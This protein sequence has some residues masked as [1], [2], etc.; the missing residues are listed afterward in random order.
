MRKKPSAK[1]TDF[2]IELNDEQ[3]EAKRYI[4]HNDI[5]VLSG[6]AGSGK[7]LLACQCALDDLFSK[8]VKKIYITR[9]TVSE[10][11]IGFLPGNLKDKMEPWLLPIYENIS[12]CYGANA[13]KRNRIKKLMED[14][15]IEI[16][17]IA[18]MRGRTKTNSYI[19]VDECQNVTVEQI[20]MIVTR[21]GKGSKLIFCGDIS[22]IDL[23]KKNHSGLD[24]LI[25]IGMG[26]EGFEHFELRSNHRHSIVDK[27][28]EKF[29]D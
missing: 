24:F 16:S 8:K 22:Q 14:N 26:I 28:I 7:T 4:I 2:D 1:K 13:D 20:K 3:K 12:V 5:I 9:P 27:F 18:Y 23:S 11:K 19:I 25:S 29:N 10:E 6:K 15:I 17:P 21:M